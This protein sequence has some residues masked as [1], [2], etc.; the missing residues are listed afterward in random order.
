MGRKNEGHLYGGT[1]TWQVRQIDSMYTF[2]G[3]S[4]VRRLSNICLLKSY[5]HHRVVPRTR[6]SIHAQRSVQTC[7]A[8]ARAVLAHL[9]VVGTRRIQ[10]T[11]F[12]PLLSLLVSGTVSAKYVGPSLS[13]RALDV[14]MNSHAYVLSQRLAFSYRK[15]MSDLLLESSP[16]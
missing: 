1:H 13:R 16:I 2:A 14:M 10:L 4:E 5:V 3:K 7:E 12:I 11:L 6:A 9:Y 15:G 8:W